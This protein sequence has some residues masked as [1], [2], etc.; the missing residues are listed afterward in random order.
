VKSSNS[1]IILV[2]STRY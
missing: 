2:M 1:Y